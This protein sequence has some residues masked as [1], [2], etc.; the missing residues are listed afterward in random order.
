MSERTALYRFYDAD[1]VLLYVGISAE[2]H[3]RRD[4][5]RDQ[6]WWPEVATQVIECV[7]TREQAQH[8]ELRAI[9]RERPKYNRAGTLPDDTVAA[10]ETTARPGADRAPAALAVRAD[11]RSLLDE[12]KAAPDASERGAL[13]TEFLQEMKGFNRDVAEMRREDAMGL[14]GSGWTYQQIGERFGPKGKPLHLT[15]IR[16]IIQGQAT[17]RWAKVARDEAAAKED[18]EI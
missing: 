3:G 11:L 18:P 13:A 17:G 4:Q 10:V 12:I 14:H 15:R 2:P 5:H 9:R 16:Q 6:T 1:G 8:E 7:D